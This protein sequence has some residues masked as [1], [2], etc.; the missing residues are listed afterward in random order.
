MTL[1]VLT[2]E[3]LASL[4]IGIS[5]LQ[6][7]ILTLG[8]YDE[9]KCCEIFVEDGEQ[10][11][12]PCLKEAKPLNKLL[13][14]YTVMTSRMYSN[15]IFHIRW[16]KVSKESQAQLASIVLQHDDAVDVSKAVEVIND[17]VLCPAFTHCTQL[18]ND[19]RNEIIQFGAME[20]LFAPLEEGTIKMTIERLSQATAICSSVSMKSLQDWV[21]HNPEN[22]FE[23]DDFIKELAFETLAADDKSTW[24]NATAKRIEWWVSMQDLE[25]AANIIL[26]VLKFMGIQVEKF[27]DLQAY[28]ADVSVCG[29]GN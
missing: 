23:P 19:L 10:L 24:I 26:N 7:K 27:P 18:I 5:C 3:F 29:V 11:Y 17:H 22:V 8:N 20:D 13:I 1:V 16:R 12:F 4:L 28:S 14:P 2:Y 25:G 6:Q 9:L 21:L 15:N